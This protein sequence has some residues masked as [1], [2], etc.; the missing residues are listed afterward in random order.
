MLM[1]TY[2]RYRTVSRKITHLN[3]LQMEV[4]L[5]MWRFHSRKNQR[6]LHRANQKIRLLMKTQSRD[7]T[8]RLQETTHLIQR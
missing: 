1:R 2:H 4:W 8:I 5:L 7:Q 6:T 3:C